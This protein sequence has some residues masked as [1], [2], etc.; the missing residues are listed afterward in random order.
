MNSTKAFNEVDALKINDD[1]IVDSSE[2]SALKICKKRRKPTTKNL[3]AKFSDV[4]RNVL[5]K[6]RKSDFELINLG[7]TVIIKV[8]RTIAASYVWSFKGY[9]YQNYWYLAHLKGNDGE[10]L[11]KN[12]VLKF[13][14]EKEDPILFR[15]R[16]INFSQFEI[17][18]SRQRQSKRFQ[19][20]KNV[21]DKFK[22]LHF[23]ER[24]IL[25]MTKKQ[26]IYSVFESKTS[27]KTMQRVKSVKIAIEKLYQKNFEVVLT[28]Q[29]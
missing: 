12:E 10:Y 9:F 7:K 24:K 16:H 21:D 17:N 20:A 29:S 19:D 25:K 2:E 6:D 4:T 23:D 13:F 18:G 8:E 27:K 15:V 14:L 3:C 1:I 22:K 28:I 11:W 26:A 5:K